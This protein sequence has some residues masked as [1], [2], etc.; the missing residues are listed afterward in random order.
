MLGGIEHVYPHLLDGQR[1]P[2]L[3]RMSEVEGL[4]KVD[5]S[6]DRALAGSM[7]SSEPTPTIGTA[8]ARLPFRALPGWMSA[9][10]R[11]D[12]KNAGLWSCVRCVSQFCRR[13]RSWGSSRR[14][15]T[16]QIQLFYTADRDNQQPM[17]QRLNRQTE[18]E[19]LAARMVD[20]RD[21]LRYFITN[22]VLTATWRIA[23]RSDVS[24][25]ARSHD[26][27]A[28]PRCLARATR[29]LSRFADGPRPAIPA[30]SSNRLFH[31]QRASLHAQRRSA[32]F[33]RLRKE[34]H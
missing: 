7:R 4:F 2:L 33:L 1:V 27:R 16:E 12:L 24:R 18:A 25:A 17:W 19:R 32:P 20:A 11:P 34:R 8:T 15:A 10:C 13:Q 9:P 31:R 30:A 14:D 29:K 21:H 3:H 6:A 23:L 26:D 5:F 28:G 22:N